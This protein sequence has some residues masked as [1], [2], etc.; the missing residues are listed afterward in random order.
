MMTSF[1]KEKISV[2][3]LEGVHPSAVETFTADGYSTVVRHPATLEGAALVEAIREAHIVG[4]RSR[5]QLTA[6]VLKQARRL[7]TVGCFCIGTD[8]VDLAFA[9]ER[10]VPVFNA[11]FS[12][13]RSVAE[14]VIA[15]AILL[16]RGIPQRNAQLHRG[17]WNKSAAGAHEIRGKCL[18]IVGYGHIGTQVGV[19][20]EAMGMRVVFYDI[21]TKLALGNASAVRTLDELLGQADVVTLHVPDTPATRGLI[22]TR[23]IAA[24]RQ[25]AAL[26][27]ASRG[28]VVDIEALTS[29]LESGHLGG[30]ALDVF[31][32]EPS[33]RGE[34]FDSPLLAFD[35]VILT[36]HIGGST[37]EA[38]EA[39]GREVADKLVRY[40]NLGST[41]TAVNFPE[42]SLTDHPGMHR[43]IHIH[44][45]RPGL[46]SQINAVFSRHNVNICS[47]FLETSARLGYVVIDV[48]AKETTDRRLLRQ[49]LDAIEGTIRTRV[50]Y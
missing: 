29:A 12:N 11:P 40:S 13:T 14:L 8:Q 18:G 9:A 45:N 44:Q 42:V 28:L 27:N 30:A 24:M 35:Q 4:I 32:A 47:E 5:T 25:G 34:A 3:L 37:E 6:D 7:I 36:P 50:L 39:I 31:P 19:L 22:G 23:Q 20:A 49:E 43:L 26:I 48:E 33:G 38:Q 2:V 15:E 10:G 46:L 17:L 41:L 1:P 16:V 21:I